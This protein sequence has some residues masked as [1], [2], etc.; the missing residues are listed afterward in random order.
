MRKGLCVILVNTIMILACAFPVSAEEPDQKI[1][2][3]GYFENEIFQGGAKEGEVK[4]GYAYEYYR[5]LSEYT[6]WEYSYTYGDFTELYQMLLDGRIDMLAGLA[7]T[8][9]RE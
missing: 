3:I 9:E 5:K 6:G 2:K 4:N 7:R 1:V 8:E